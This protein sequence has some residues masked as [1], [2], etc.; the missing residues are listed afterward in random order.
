LLE[1]VLLEPVEHSA[2]NND[3]DH[4]VNLDSICGNDS[5][6][7]KHASN[8]PDGQIW[9]FRKISSYARH[10]KSIAVFATKL[11]TTFL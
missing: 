8:E 4:E 3:E 10:E 2:N 5:L 9:P 1:N 7:I 6:D 11:N